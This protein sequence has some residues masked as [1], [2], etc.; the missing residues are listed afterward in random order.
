MT[1]SCILLATL[2]AALIGINTSISSDFFTL[3]GGHSVRQPG[4]NSDDGSYYKVLGHGINRESNVDEI[5]KAYRKKAMLLHPDKGGDTEDFKT[6]TEAYEV[7]PTFV[8]VQ[9]KTENDFTYTLTFRAFTIRSSRIP[10]RSRFTINLES[11]D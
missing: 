10:R 8:A 4:D 11:L 1:L 2:L 9:L 7:H 5:K 6:L 3:S